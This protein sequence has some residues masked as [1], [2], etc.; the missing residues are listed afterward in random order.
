V[1]FEKNLASFTLSNHGQDQQ[2]MV[3]ISEAIP[4]RFYSVMDSTTGF[5]LF[6]S[7]KDF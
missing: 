1:K 4:N 7:R 6:H 2:V 3:N 5:F